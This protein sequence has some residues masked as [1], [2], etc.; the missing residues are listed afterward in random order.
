MATIAATIVA[1]TSTCEAVAAQ[2]P[3]VDA[4]AAAA[5]P[6]NLAQAARQL[7][8]LGVLDVG[9][10]VGVDVDVDVDVG[11]VAVPVAPVRL[12]LRLLS[13]AW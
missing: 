4:A 1:A 8:T 3:A 9:V 5:I 10:G 6:T 12:R 13:R 7:A 11:P 2:Q